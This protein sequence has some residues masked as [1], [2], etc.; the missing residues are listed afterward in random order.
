[1]FY[2]ILIGLS[3]GQIMISNNRLKKLIPIFIC[4][5]LIGATFAAARSFPNQLENNRI[6]T[7]M[8]PLPESFDLRDYNGE[9]F[10]TSIKS[11][12][13][14]T[15]WTH[16]AMAA[17]E[18]NLLMTG[19]WYEVETEDIGEPNLAEYHLD[20]W[21]GFNTFQN[22]DDPDGTG[23]DVHYGGDYLVTS[24]YLSRGDGAVRDVDGQSFYE[25]PTFTDSSYHYYYPDH[26][27]WYTVGEN[28]E[29]IEI[30]KQSIM[31]HGAIGTCMA[32]GAASLYNWTHFYNGPEDPNHAITIIGWDDNKLTIAQEP[33]A[34]L[35]KNSW[36][37]SW[38]LDGYFWISYYDVHAGHHP[39]MGAISFQE[40]KPLSFDT[41][42][43]HDYHGWRDTKEDCTEAINAFIAEEDHS[44]SAVSFFT[45]TD[46][47]DYTITIYDDFNNN[48]LENQL[49]S[50]TGK[51]SY[52]GFHTID[53]P[54]LVSLNS[55][56]DFYLYLS[57]S[58]GGQPYDCT[59][60]I[61]VLLGTFSTGTT[62][63]SDASPG[64][65]F[66]KDDAGNWVDLTSF[67]E[68]ANFCIKGLVPKQADLVS[69]G[70][71]TVNRAKPGSTI[72][73]QINIENN[74]ESFSNLNW[75]IDSFPSWGEWEFSKTNGDDIYPESGVISLNLNVS[76]PDEKGQSFD[77][78]IVIV[79]QHDERDTERI[80]V[81][82]ST[83][84]SY[85]RLPSVPII[86]KIMFIIDEFLLQIQKS[87]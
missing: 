25:P 29:N 31:T 39:E 57:L 46:N 66:Y 32:Y 64:E 19:N 52:R 6:E 74:G 35:C 70:S 68:S 24:A 65:S 76:L 22:K 14:G 63:V 73:T 78:E 54:E 40:V 71:I 28:L 2:I 51:I 34:W 8:N 69:D 62:V 85:S 37:A 18:S 21:N 47:V 7:E 42:Y 49:V 67:D 83:T 58:H 11:Q 75:K 26:I 53:L 80:P 4:V 55:G 12:S 81:T 3:R 9:N 50:T 82:I 36:G 72:Q 79:N 45:A 60:E 33:G 44:L 59:S 20:W 48:E 38:G 16:G 56:D 41:I 43:Y 77:G 27:E 15:C 10:V 61:P 23:L 30:I 84:N 1:M 13:G 5:F 87:L 86:E 17:M